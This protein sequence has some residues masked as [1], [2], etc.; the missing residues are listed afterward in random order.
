MPQN[1]STES[2]VAF[3][4]LSGTYVPQNERYLHLRIESLLDLQKDLK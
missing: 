1:P 3:L 2:L 4:Y